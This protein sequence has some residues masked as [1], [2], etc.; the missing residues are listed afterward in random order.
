MVVAV[1]KAPYIHGEQ[2]YSFTKDVS[3][4]FRESLQI[5]NVLSN[6]LAIVYS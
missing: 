2:M 3:M 1:E 6:A 4:G 5:Q